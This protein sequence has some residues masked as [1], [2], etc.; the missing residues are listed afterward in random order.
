MRDA[1]THGVERSFPTSFAHAIP[2]GQ[3]PEMSA[4]SANDRRHLHRS[5]PR[6][7]PCDMPT[8]TAVARRPRSPGRGRCSWDLGRASRSWCSAE[9]DACCQARAVK[10]FGNGHVAGAVGREVLAQGPGS[11]QQRTGRVDPDRPS[12]QVGARLDRP[13]P[14]EFAE[15]AVSPD[16]RDH[17]D[18]QPVGRTDRSIAHSVAGP[19]PVVAAVDHTTIWVRL[20]WSDYAAAGRTVSV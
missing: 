7:H 6:A 12:E 17:L 5:C 16:D 8:H 3:G 20:C 19:M 9:C 11:L 18:A 2:V 13:R 4:A 14:R 1:P 15:A 10:C